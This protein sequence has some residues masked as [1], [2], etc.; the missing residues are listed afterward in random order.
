MILPKDNYKSKKFSDLSPLAVV[1][2]G[3][4]AGDPADGA[5]LELQ[6]QLAVVHCQHD[7]RA[8]LV[9]SGKKNDTL[10]IVGAEIKF[11]RE[12]VTRKE[13]RTNNNEVR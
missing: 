8:V 11:R 13:G 2:F 1:D 6:L 12:A 9:T 3:S 10:G 7:P 4:A 5:V